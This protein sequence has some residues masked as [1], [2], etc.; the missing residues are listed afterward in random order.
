[1]NTDIVV[2][3]SCSHWASTSYSTSPAGPSSPYL[4]HQSQW[5][6][7]P[8]LSS[9]AAD[10]DD[11][12]FE[13]QLTSV[14]RRSPVPSQ[15]TT[16]L[17]STPVAISFPADNNTTTKCQDVLPVNPSASFRTPSPAPRF[18]GFANTSLE[19]SL[20]SPSTD[21]N[22]A[23]NTSSTRPGTNKVFPSYQ[24]IAVHYGL[25]RNLPPPPR[26]IAQRSTSSS[27]PDFSSMRDNYL[28]MLAQ[29]SSDTM[30]TEPTTV[31][32]S[33]LVSAEDAQAKAFMAIAELTG[34]P[35][36]LSRRRHQPVA[37][38]ASAA[39]PEFQSLGDS[40]PDDFTA[41]PLFG[42]EPLFDEGGLFNDAPLFGDDSPFLTSP[43]EPSYDDFG[44]SP[45]DTP[46]SEFM[47]TPLMTMDDVFDSPVIADRGY[48][49]S[50]P[51]FGGATESSDNVP[52]SL[53]P[54][55]KLWTFS[56]ST[57]SL[58]SMDPP[59][60]TKTGPVI[61]PAPQRRRTTATGTRKNITAESL[62]PLDAPT[63]RRTY[64]TPSATSRKA[65]PAGF[66]KRLA[67]EAFGDEEAELA[68][69]AG[70]DPESIEWK[71]RQNTIAARKSR[72]RK[73]EHQQMLEDQ[74]AT[75]K[76]EVTMWRER[77][78]M[79]QE[80]LRS[81]GIKCSIETMDTQP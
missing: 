29:K 81:A 40:F 6:T 25:P 49:D 66:R 54:T 73:L 34:I 14:C 60:T 9:T 23:I 47:P 3:P 24:H 45:M 36:S 30:A 18:N 43:H 50:L 56:P 12:E 78:L 63:Q 13:P 64:V 74:A 7:S 28:T 33:A 61:P 20:S 31:A 37:H 46:F 15:A 1:M 77:A 35:S 42:D 69:L 62:I 80:M 44:T 39:S 10:D 32:P 26:P 8:M 2:D 68:E 4:H 22:V 65:V 5:H 57:P 59:A 48:N 70:V 21:Q 17:T 58:D 53:P 67:S 55:D 16:L 51:L 75:L 11:D 79:A 41:S 27:T 19:S 52:K 76:R 38:S 72:K 71:R